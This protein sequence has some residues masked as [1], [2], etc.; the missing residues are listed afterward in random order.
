MDPH[1][2]GDR[3]TPLTTVFTLFSRSLKNLDTTSWKWDMM[4]INSLSI[5]E[6]LLYFSSGHFC[7][8]SF[9]QLTTVNIFVYQ[10]L[11]VFQVFCNIQAFLI[12]R[13]R[14]VTL[15]IIIICLH[16]RTYCVHLRLTSLVSIHLLIHLSLVSL[17]IPALIVY[18]S[19]TLSPQAQTYLFNKSFAP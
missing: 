11:L 7:D 2:V 9:V 13:I 10:L 6:L 12:L 17:I 15:C 19:I 8:T 5:T 14:S 4:D 16:D 1:N 3:L 18:H